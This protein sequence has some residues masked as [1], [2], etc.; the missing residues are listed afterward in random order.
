LGEEKSLMNYGIGVGL[1]LIVAAQPAFA[2]QALKVV[3]PPPNHETTAERIFL[4]GTAA[5]NTEVTV[6]G[7][8]L[9]ERSPSGHFSPSFPLQ[10]GENTFTLRSGAQT[11]SLT[12]RRKSTSS[13]LPKGLGFLEGSLSPT[14]DVARSPNEPI[15]FSAIATPKTQVSVRIAGQTIALTPQTQATLPPNSAVLTG[16]NQATTAQ[17]GLYQGC[18]AF[19]KTGELGQPGFELRQGKTLISKPGAGKI[20]ILSPQTISTIEVTSSQGVARTG[21]STDYS[22]LTPL[23]KGTQAKITGR[24]GEWLRLDYGGWI[25]QS[26]TR[27]IQTA[28]TQSSIRSVRVKTLADRTD[29]IFPLQ[30]PVPVAVQQQPGSFTLTLYNTIAQT[31]TIA[32]T[33]D[34]VLSRLDWHQTAPDRLEYRIQLKTQQ[35]WGYDLRYE[36]TSLILSLRHPPKL[37]ANKASLDGTTIL[38]DPGHGSKNDLGSVGPTGY[39]EKDVALIVSKLLRTEL[40]RRGAKVIMTREGDDDLYPNPRAAKIEQ[41]SPTIALSL[42]YNALPDGGDAWNT[43]GVSTYWYHPQAQN[44]AVFLHDYLVQKL[45]RPSYGVYW[46]NLALTRPAIAPSALIELG[47]MTNPNEF[48]WVTDPRSQKQLATALAQG[49]AA[50]FHQKSL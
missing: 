1:A 47:F 2:E 5:P 7:Q 26:E 48:E 28:L 40:E 31:D 39:P 32:Q 15:C 8:V 21:P 14:V 22:R 25:K 37:S 34:A 38:L 35:Q 36:G 29:I 3:Y 23:P 43:K 27:P 9:R 20:D 33:P 49:I 11:L 13:S 30:I 6:N 16:S 17:P 4:I 45:K 44:L 41:T 19:T 12:V 24:E 50:W 10:L 46:N 18:T 42:H